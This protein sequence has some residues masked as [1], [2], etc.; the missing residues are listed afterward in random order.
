MPFAIGCVSL[1]SIFVDND[2][3]VSTTRFFHLSHSLF[4]QL[5]SY[6]EVKEILEVLDCCGFVMVSRSCRRYV[7]ILPEVIL[8]RWKM[9]VV[10]MCLR[11][12]FLIQR[13]F[14]T[15][16]HDVEWADLRKDYWNP[17]RKLWEMTKQKQFWNALAFCA[18]VKIHECR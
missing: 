9:D 12:G 17:K 6:I 4:V 3:R 2:V 7:M 5:T 18:L 1:A 11:T 14:T 16:C 15:V 8:L 10:W 13:Y